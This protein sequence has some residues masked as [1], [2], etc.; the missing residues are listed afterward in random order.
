MKKRRVSNK[1]ASKLS[2]STKHFEIAWI[3]C[4][5]QR[6]ANSNITEETN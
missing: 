3:P 6:Q 4:S 1:G 5:I 2:S